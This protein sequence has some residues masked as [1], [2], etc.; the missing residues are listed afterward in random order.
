MKSIKTC[1]DCGKHKS[2]Q[3]K[4]CKDCY[5]KRLR[6]TTVKHTTT[7]KTWAEEHGRPPSILET[8]KIL[9]AFGVP[10]SCAPHYRRKAFGKIGR[11][12][13]C[14][15]DST[16][17]RCQI[18]ELKEEGKSLIEIAQ[19]FG[20]AASSV[21]YA[22]RENKL[23]HRVTSPR[24]I[25]AGKG[26]GKWYP[27]DCPH[28]GK[29]MSANHSQCWDCYVKNRW[30]DKPDRIQKLK[31]W[32]VDNGRRPTGKEGAQLLGV[33]ENTVHEYARE[34]ERQLLSNS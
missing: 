7:L 11:V 16:A 18:T 12:G 29:I 30:P 8:V 23:G 22:L 13:V 26:S 34:I 5:W 3:A 32:M 25:N 4:Q 19:H 17:T 28:C 33:S 2:P 1:Q 21:S 31:Q 27:R 9:E 15:D 24:R 14:G 20:I 6:Q 10:K